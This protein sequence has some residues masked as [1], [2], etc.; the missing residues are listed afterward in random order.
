MEEPSAG[1]CKPRTPTS[2]S[3]PQLA[4]D[5]L[6]SLDHGLELWESDPTRR[7]VEAAIGIDPEFFRRHILERDADAL[8]NVLRR[9][10]IKRFLIDQAGAEL[11]SAPHLLPEIDLGHLPIGEFQNELIRLGVE[12]A[13][14]ELSKGALHQ[15]APV[16]IAEADVHGELGVH[17]LDGR[18]EN[19]RQF[20]AVLVDLAES[21]FIDLNEIR[22]S[23]YQRLKLFVDDSDK[24]PGEFLLI[25]VACGDSCPRGKGRP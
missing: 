10:D 21:R 20:L 25:P 23:R 5:D 13:G 22:T 4:P 6:C 1:E 3:M 12:N 19:G 17:A 11:L 18:V 24:I 8:G 2:N 9:L 7:R 16:V 15:R 14:K